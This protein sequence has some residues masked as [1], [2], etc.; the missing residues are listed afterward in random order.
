MTEPLQ[1]RLL[2][3]SSALAEADPNSLSELMSRDPES[4]QRQDRDRIISALREQRARLAKAEAETPVRAKAP[5]T[6][7]SLSM[8]TTANAED[9][10]L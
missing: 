6:K 5:G 9:L 8:K 1:P 2:P 3:Q 10:G 4:Y 7:I